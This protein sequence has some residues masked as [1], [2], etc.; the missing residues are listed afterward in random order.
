MLC[1]SLSDLICSSLK[2]I[3]LKKK[4]LSKNTIFQKI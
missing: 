2:E 1:H 4:L 3:T